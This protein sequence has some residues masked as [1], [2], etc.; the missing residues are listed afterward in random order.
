MTLYM[1]K[2]EFEIK[3]FNFINISS[4]R[5]STFFLFKKIK[6]R[7]IILSRL[8]RHLSQ[9]YGAFIDLLVRSKKIAKKNT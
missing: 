5:K 4:M 6:I 1:I 3:H 9:A 2:G 8:K 7:L